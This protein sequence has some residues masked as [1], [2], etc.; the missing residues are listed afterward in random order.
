MKYVIR[1]STD[2]QNNNDNQGWSGFQRITSESDCY[3]EVEVV[4][5]QAATKFDYLKDVI[6]LD[7]GSTLQAT[8]MNPDF[9]TGIRVSQNPIGMKTNAGTKRLNLEGKVNGLGTAWF[10]PEHCA[11]IF[12]FSH[13]VDKNRITYDSDQE[14]AFLVHTKNGIVKFK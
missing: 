14:D 2:N 13:V 9:I 1:E 10:D 8:I 11:N 5:K 7:T 6:L 3:P 4:N 12:G